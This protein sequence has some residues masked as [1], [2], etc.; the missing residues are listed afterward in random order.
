[1]HFQYEFLEVESE[2]KWGG[3]VTANLTPH[4]Y[5]A[6]ARLIFGEADLA[7]GSFFVLKHYLDFLDMSIPL[8]VAC[9]SFL[10]PNPS[11][12]PRYLALILPFNYKLWALVLCICFAFAPLCLYALSKLPIHNTEYHAFTGRSQVVFTCFSIMSQVALHI[13]PRFWA[14]RMFIGWFW[15]FCLLITLAYKG[16]MVSF[17]TIP[18]FENP[19][20]NID[21]LV[22]SGLKIGG[23]GT[24][25]HRLFTQYT[26]TNGHIGSK[27]VLRDRYEVSKP[28]EVCTPPKST[29]PS[30]IKVQ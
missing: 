9:T 2:T 15:M 20:D 6:V 22:A 24:E 25:L 17:L 13:W 5:G 23:W 12:R 7:I 19:I 30:E 27:A 8:D 26:T 10:T 14:V 1:M 11:T 16:A 28:I 29:F 3:Q 4:F 18:L 21:D